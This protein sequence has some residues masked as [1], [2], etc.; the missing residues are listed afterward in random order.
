[1]DSIAVILIT[2]FYANAL[3]INNEYSIPAQLFF[4][5][6]SS[7]LFKVIFALLDTIPFYYGTK[8]LRKYLAIEDELA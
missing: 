3:P 8:F 1:V 4:F 6:L 7:Y 2:Y 5:V